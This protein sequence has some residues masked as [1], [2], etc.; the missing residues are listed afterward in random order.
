MIGLGSTERS[1]LR[2]LVGRLSRDRPMRRNGLPR[3][4]ERCSESPSF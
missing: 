1:E 3:R 4:P 2:H